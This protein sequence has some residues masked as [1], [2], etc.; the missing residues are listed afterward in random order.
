MNSTISCLLICR[1]RDHEAILDWGVIDELF[2]LA[3]LKPIDAL[4]ALACM[5]RVFQTWPQ[6][7]RQHDVKE[8]LDHLRTFIPVLTHMQIESRM[9]LPEGLL[10]QD[11]EFRL[12]APASVTSSACLQDLITVWHSAEAGIK[13]CVVAPRLLALTVPRFNYEAGIAVRLGGRIS[14]EPGRV[15]IPCFRD[16]ITLDLQWVEYK[17]TCCILHRGAGLDSGHLYV[18]GSE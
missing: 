7:H 15:Q 3:A 12:V 6:V 11:E 8:F 13:G 5:Q 2:Q 9:M 10:R 18:S 14:C 16:N 4:P 17:V 1:D